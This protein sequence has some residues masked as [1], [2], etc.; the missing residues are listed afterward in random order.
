M[1]RYLKHFWIQKTFPPHVAQKNDNADDFNVF[2]QNTIY[3][4]FISLTYTQ[5]DNKE[6]LLMMVL[7]M[8]ML[9]MIETKIP[10]AATKT[11]YDITAH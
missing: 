4:I 9:V 2:K 6:D 5:H 11:L 3:V 1:F 10:S 7:V 8:V